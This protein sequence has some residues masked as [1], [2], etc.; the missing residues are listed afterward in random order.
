MPEVP[1]KPDELLMLEMAFKDCDNC[2]IGI[3]FKALLEH[4]EWQ[5]KHIKDSRQNYDK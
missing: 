4:I 5:A 3:I 2:P 1:L